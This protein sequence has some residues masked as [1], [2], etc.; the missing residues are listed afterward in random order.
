MLVDT[1]RRK[2]IKTNQQK[3]NGRTSP[4][5][6]STSTESEM[7]SSSSTLL[8]PVT[9]LNTEIDDQ[10]YVSPTEQTPKL[11]M[12]DDDDLTRQVEQ[13]FRDNNEQPSE[14]YSMQIN[15]PSQGKE[16]EDS[17]IRINLIELTDLLE[18]KSNHPRSRFSLSN[19]NNDDEEESRKVSPSR[20]TRSAST[21]LPIRIEI[22]SSRRRKSYSST[23]LANDLINKSSNSEKHSTTDLDKVNR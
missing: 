20:R 14:D 12:F 4:S 7:I 22:N 3:E 8:E 19:N 6:N 1:P 10:G 9:S 5:T 15:Q 18:P 2:L 23:G 13:C 11:S 16:Y 17:F 21:T